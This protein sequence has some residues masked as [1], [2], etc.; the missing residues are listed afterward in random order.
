MKTAPPAALDQFSTFTDIAPPGP[1]RYASPLSVIGQY[2]RA[3]EFLRQGVSHDEVR[4]PAA[5]RSQQSP[6][7]VRRQCWGVVKLVGQEVQSITDAQFQGVCRTRESCNYRLGWLDD[8][9]ENTYR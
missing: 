7:G 5:S 2:P 1:T 4:L 8:E 6:G 9:G 3:E